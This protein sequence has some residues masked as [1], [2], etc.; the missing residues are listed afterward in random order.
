MKGTLVDSLLQLAMVAVVYHIL[1]YM[2]FVVLGVW[3]GYPSWVKKKI[4]GCKFQ[5]F[6]TVVG[7]IV[8]MMVISQLE[9]DPGEVVYNIIFF[10]LIFIT[11]HYILWMFGKPLWGRQNR[12]LMQHWRIVWFAI[13]LILAF[14]ILSQ[15]PP[16]ASSVG[17]YFVS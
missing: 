17:F 11:V 6:W 5:I 13:G 7:F 9:V 15:T 2:I 1:C 12:W 14:N 3:K 10:G 16:V 4:A 8:G